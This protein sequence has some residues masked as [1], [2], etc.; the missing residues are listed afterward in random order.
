LAH[1]SPQAKRQIDR[2]SHFA[3]LTEE[4]RRA[5]WRHLANTIELV[6]PSEST[7][8]TANRSVQPFFAQVTSESPCTY[9]WRPH[10]PKLS[11]PMGDMDPHVTRFLGPI[12][13][14]TQ[15]APRS[16]QPFLRRRQKRVR[17]VFNIAPSHGGSGPHLIHGS[18]GPPES[19]TQT[20]SRSL[21]PFLRGSVTAHCVT[22]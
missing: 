14:I 20:A 9:N 5:H 18:L 1:S 21:Q 16:V 12:R 4:C 11:L 17:I 7:T 22:D 19:E 15:T 10:P 8:Q 6:H 3:Q 2:L 13:A